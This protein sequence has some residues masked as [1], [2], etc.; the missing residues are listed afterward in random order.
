MWETCHQ[1]PSL[2]LLPLPC[3]VTVVVGAW[4]EEEWLVVV[5]WPPPGVP[6]CG[7]AGGVPGCVFPD[8]VTPGVEWG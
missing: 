8:A 5:V 1:V 7:F 2:G 4:A 6:G 3:D